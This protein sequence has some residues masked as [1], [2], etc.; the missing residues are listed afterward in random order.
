MLEKYC[1]KVVKSDSMN[2]HIKGLIVMVIKSTQDLELNHQSWRAMITILCATYNKK[3]SVYVTGLP[4]KCVLMVMGKKILT[5]YSPRL[6]DVKIKTYLSSYIFFSGVL[7]GV[8]A[9]KDDNLSTNH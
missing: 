6:K 4:T 2:A 9:C 7:M 1:P 8:S 3:E 5:Q